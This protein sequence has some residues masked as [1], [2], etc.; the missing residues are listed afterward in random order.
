ML[1]VIVNVLL[2][3][4]V[5]FGVMAVMTGSAG[6]AVMVN[7]SGLEA[8][9]PAPFR[10][11]TLREPAVSEAVNTTCVPVRELGVIAVPSTSTSAVAGLKLTP[12]TV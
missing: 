9:P 1:P 12:L 7:V 2:P 8:V 3:L 6:A 11:C 5:G 4:G 10:T